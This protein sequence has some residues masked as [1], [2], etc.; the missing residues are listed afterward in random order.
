MPNQA[1]Q[2]GFL[3]KCPISAYSAS[4]PVTQRK[5]PPSTRKLVSPLENRKS[6][7]YSGFNAISTAG[8][9][10]IPQMPSAAMEKNHSA[11]IGPKTLPMRA[12]PK[13]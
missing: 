13:G 4:A 3:P 5:T 10:I 2:I 11:I 1:S 12:V 9:W 8:C 6:M 7:P